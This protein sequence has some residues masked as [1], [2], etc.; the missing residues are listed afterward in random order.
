MVVISKDEIRI[1]AERVEVI[2]TLQDEW[3]RRLVKSVILTRPQ[4][5]WKRVGN[6]EVYDP[7]N[8]L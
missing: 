8:I 6:E 7:R 2:Y 1:D 3:N 4:R 5:E